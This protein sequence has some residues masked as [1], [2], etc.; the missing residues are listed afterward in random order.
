[1]TAPQWFGAA[2]TIAWFTAAT[3]CLAG[4]DPVSVSGSQEERWVGQ[5]ATFYV[6]LRGEGP[7]TGAASFSLPQVSRCVI[8]KIGNPVVGVEEHEG[9]SWYTQTHEFALFSQR[10]GSIE[11]PAFPVRFS[12]NKDANSDPVDQS[13]QTSPLTFTIRRPAGGDADAFLVTTSDISIT[14]EWDPLPGPAQQGAVFHRTIRQTAEETTGMALA[15]PPL[16]A[17]DGVRVHPGKPAVTD[18]NERGELRGSRSDTITYVLEKSGSLS[19]PAIKYVWWD[20]DQE[21]FGSKTLPAATFDVAAAAEP[22]PPTAAEPSNTYAW[23]L[24]LILAT[25]TMLLGIERQGLVA[26][27]R[28]LAVM[29]N[30][31]ERVA[32]RELLRACRRNDAQGAESSWLRWRSVRG[33]EAAFPEALRQAVLGLERFLYGPVQ[34]SPWDGKELAHAFSQLDAERKCCTLSRHPSLPRLNPSE[35]VDG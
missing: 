35:T 33:G 5:K 27:W 8:V 29:L 31:P 32:A 11:V 18:R 20:A 6:T 21:E 16:T 10:D 28:R 22:T 17:S 19:A 14:E 24:G 3:V 2:A 30:P 15:P 12:N 4:V 26:G 34:P 13:A 9:E 7:F 25:G 1:M 23:L